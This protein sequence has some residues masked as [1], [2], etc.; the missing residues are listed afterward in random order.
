V[1]RHFIAKTLKIRPV[2]WLAEKGGRVLGIAPFFLRRHVGLGARLTSVPYLNTGGILAE[3]TEMALAL[4]ER[5]Q[6]W[7]QVQGVG[8][9]ELR[10][11][12]QPLGDYAP[13]QGR[14]VSIIPLAGDEK[15]AWEG[16]KAVA[17]N[18]IRK[19]ES[20]G[21]E[22][23]HGFDNLEAFWPAYADNM[24]LLGA[25]VLAKG[26]FQALGQT[27]ELKPHLITLFH[28]G[29]PVGGMVLLG[30]RDRAENGWTASTRAARSLYTNDLLYWAAMRWALERGY[31]WLDLGRSQAGGGHERFKEKFGAQTRPLP[32]QELR[33]HNGA[34]VGQTEE[35]S[36]LYAAFTS[37]WTR[38]PL[39]LATRL[40][41]YVSRQIY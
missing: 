26:W 37:V 29:R 22:I 33:Y 16:M 4:L 15:S 34:W 17:R 18:R 8:V 36:A 12:Y 13:R 25:P 27:P 5:V 7:A 2:Y 32:Y 41:P 30:W 39:P 28:A 3:D 14:T 20:A 10:N 9:L 38:L 40:G 21:L 23:R 35:P 19:A 11:R 24:H 6:T 1:W 31:R